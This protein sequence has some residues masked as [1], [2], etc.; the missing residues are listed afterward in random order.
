[1]AHQAVLAFGFGLVTASVLALAAVG[2]TLQFGVMSYI[3]FAYGSYIGLAGY[4]AWELNARAGWNLWLA[5]V[6]SA[7][8]LALFAI[9]VDF[10]LLRRFVNRSWPRIYMLIVTLGLWLILSNAL[11]AIWGPFPRQFRGATQLPL[12]VGPFLLTREQ[13]VIMAVAACVLTG[14]H[15]LL[16]RTRLGKA[17]R[18]MSDDKVLA[19]ASG[20]DAE[21]IAMLT[22][23]IVGALIGLAG[24]VLAINLS[25]FSYTYGD[26]Y[27]FVVFAAV[28]LGGIGQPYGTMLGALLIGVVTEM[29]TVFINAAYKNDIA[30]AMLIVVLFFRPRGLFPAKGSQ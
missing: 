30:F 6:G 7:V 4:I 21:R 28:I 26:N 11:I 9:A 24:C 15:L 12:K 16:T 1:M 2:V 29:S 13:L 14:V 23:L 22:W 17:M 27:L 8:C 18:A 3:N 20:I 10:V 5:V 19:G 25:S